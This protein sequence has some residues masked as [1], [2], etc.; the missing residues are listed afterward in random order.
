MSM[1]PDK[2]MEEVKKQMLPCWKLD[3]EGKEYFD[4][5]Q[6][7]KNLNVIHSLLGR[8]QNK[9]ATV[10]SFNNTTKQNTTQ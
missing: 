6:L 5:E 3:A 7:A 9:L 1:T 8:F 2:L 10:A 4:N